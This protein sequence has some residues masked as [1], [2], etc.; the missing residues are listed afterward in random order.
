MC[1]GRYSNKKNCRHVLWQLCLHCC[2]RNTASN[3]WMVIPEKRLIL[4]DIIRVAIYSMIKLQ[5]VERMTQETWYRHEEQVPCSLLPVC[6]SPSACRL[7][8]PS[9]WR[10]ICQA[11]SVVSIPLQN[12]HVLAASWP[13]WLSPLSGRQKPH[14]GKALGKQGLLCQVT[15]HYIVCVKCNRSVKF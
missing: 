6:F 3:P 10:R 1:T 4:E 5:R 13:S 9:F 7:W 15:S 11:P 8:T 14:Q 2:R 12:F